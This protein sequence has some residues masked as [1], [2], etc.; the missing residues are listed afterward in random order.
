M[1]RVF[2]A[3]S[4]WVYFWSDESRP[5]EPVHVHIA[6]GAPKPGATKVWITRAGMCLLYNNDSNIDLVILRRLMRIIEARADEV[7]SKWKEHFGA[8]SYYC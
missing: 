1:P 2:K 6:E 4:Y 5:L 3:G 7:L 8:L